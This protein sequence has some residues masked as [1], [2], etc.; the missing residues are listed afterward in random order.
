MKNYLKKI[1]TLIITLSMVIPMP[2]EV[3][4]NPENQENQT[5]ETSPKTNTMELTL[6]KVETGEKT[7][8]FVKNPKQPEIYTLRTDFK[9]E[10]D[11]YLIKDKKANKK[12]DIN[13]QPYVATVGEAANDEERRKVNRDIAL[14]VFG[15]YNKPQEE[16]KITYDG[17]VNAAK[18]GKPE[19]KILKHERSG[20]DAYGF[21]N[22]ALQHFLYSGINQKIQV[23]HLFQQLDNFEKYGKK[24]GEEKD[25]ITEQSGPTGSLVKIMPLPDDPIKG[26]QFKGFAPEDNVFTLIPENAN[27]YSVELR[28]NRAH[29]DVKYDCNDGTEVPARTLYYGQAIPKIHDSDVPTKVGGIFQGWK[30]S[31]NLYKKDGT[32]AFKKGEIIKDRNGKSINTLNID[33]VM[34]AEDVTFEAVWKDKPKA[35]YSVQFWVEKADHADD[36]SLLDKYEYMSTRVYKQIDTGTRPNLDNESVGEVEVEENGVKKTLPGL[37]FPDLNHTR[38]EKIWNGDK[39]DR[40]RSLFLNKFFVYNKKLTDQENADPKESNFIKSVSSTGQTIYNIYYDRQEYD[41]Y[42]TKSNALADEETFYPEI[43]GRDQKNN[44]LIKLGGPGKPYHYK[45]RFNE[46]MYKWPDDAKQTKGFTPGWQSYGWGVNYGKPKW[47]VHLDTPPYRL[48]ADQFLDMTNYD[49]WDGY[50]KNIDKGDGTKITAKDFTTLSFGIKQRKSSIPHHM[51]FWMDG[52]KPGETIIRYDL[53][54]TKA[55]TADQDYTHRSPSVL[56]FTP[57][58]SYVIEANQENGRVTEDDIDTI[59]DEREEISP[60]NNKSRYDIYGFKSPIG[61]LRFIPAFFSNADE[62]GDPLDGHSFKENGYLQFHY[63]RNK[64]PL[65]FNTDPSKTKADDEFNSTNQL[66]TFYEFP[67]KCLSP[68]LFKYDENVDQQDREYFKEDP[69]NS[70]DN[71]NNLFKLGLTDLLEVD[72]N[73]NYKKDDDGK[74]LIKRP[75]GISKDEVFKGWA[76]D[77]AGTK[78]VRDNPN[79]I[80][81]THPV[82][83]YAVW[84]T[85]DYKWNLS[86]DTDGGK[87]FAADDEVAIDKNPINQTGEELKLDAKNITTGSKRILEGD[88]T[89]KKEVQYPIMQEDKDGKQNFTVIQGQSLKDP[90]GQKGSK[91]QKNVIKDGYTFVGWEVVRYKKDAQGQ[92]TNEVDDSYRKTYGVPELYSFN[93]KVVSPISL[94][95]IW[96]KNDMTKVKVVHHFL[97]KNF[98]E[99]TT[100]PFNY[101][102][103]SQRVGNYTSAIGSKQ[104]KK[105]ILATDDELK[106]S[107]DQN[108]KKL[109]ESYNK[110]FVPPFNNSYFQSFKVK[111]PQDNSENTNNTEDKTKINDN[112]FHFFYRPF[113]IRE[114]KVNYLDE[115][116]KPLLKKENSAAEKKKI[117]EKYSIIDQ[118]NVIS[119]CRHYDARNYKPIQ[120]WKLTSDPQKQLFYDVEEATNKLKGTTATGEKGVDYFYNDNEINFFYKDIRVIDVPKD[121][122]TPEGYVR[123]KFKASEGG[124]FGEDDKGNPIKEINYDVVKGLKF[125]IIPVPKELKA[126]ETKDNNK[127]YITPEKDNHFVKWDKDS[128]LPDGTVLDKNEYVFT[129][130]FDWA[131]L[132]ADN[133]VVTES[134]KDGE[135][136]WINNFSPTLDDLKALIKIK[137]EGEKTEALP[138]DATIEFF[139]ESRNE[140]TTDDAIYE[141][142]KENNVAKDDAPRII[143]LKAKVTLK[144]TAKPKEV[145]FNIKVYKNCYEASK[146]GAKPEILDK[147][148]EDKLP[149]YVKVTVKVSEDS[150]KIYYVNPEAMVEIPEITLTDDQKK[151]INFINWTADVDE[152]NKDGAKDGVFEFDN[153]HKFTKDTVITPRGVEDVVEQKDPNKKPI[154][155]KNYIKVFVKTTD[156]ATDA[157][158][159]DK[160]FWV[161]PEKE[162]TIS[163]TN[164]EGKKPAGKD[165]TW[166]FDS[167]K[168]KANSKEYKTEIK[169]TFT[170]G[171]TIEAHYVVEPKTMITAAKTVKEKVIA[172]G[173]Q[174]TPEELVTNKYNSDDPNNKDNLP[175]GTTFKFVGTVDTSTAG[176]I[177]AKVEIKYPN[178][179]KVTKEVKIVVVEDVVEQ[180]DPNKK[181]IVPENYVKVEFEAGEGGRIE[182]TLAY[183]VNPDVEVDMTSYAAGIKKIPNVGYHTSGEDWTNEAAKTLKGTFTDLQTTFVFKF[184]KSPDIVEKTD[185]NTAIPDGYVT[186]TFKTDGNGKVAGSDEK[187]YYINPNAG[188]MLATENSA[189]EK[190]LTVPAVTPNDHYKFAGWNQNLDTT[191]PITEDKEYVAQFEQKKQIKIFFDPNGGNWNGNTLIQEIGCYEGDVIKIINAPERVGYKFL[192]W[193][194]SEYQ[195]GASYTAE[196]NHTFVAQWEKAPEP[197]T[198]TEN[199]NDK[200][201]GKT[202]I[203]NKTKSKGYNVSPNTGDKVTIYL[204]IS[205]LIA[206]MVAIVIQGSKR[207]KND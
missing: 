187:V 132:T 87:F 115:R 168:D 154:V 42:F 191:S 159:F 144:G 158:K 179:D 189:D 138:N 56:G 175:E 120:G 29:F 11:S 196:H 155:P 50:V 112:E 98:A 90:L 113:R 37:P 134:Y 186:L 176:E 80:M 36:A 26:S 188:I 41:L 49:N 185:E 180:K 85:P 207:R 66:D 148:K 126:G 13:Y 6:A 118:E 57:Y 59:N 167:W 65:R 170:D 30:P 172:K 116:A 75:E 160:T 197:G 114:Y 71:P 9:V 91:D 25:L 27:G 21:V 10:R 55:D 199:Q 106:S 28:Y 23:K 2:L 97:D 130:I 95:A 69:E 202:K 133:K 109:Y 108:I 52:F 74:Y 131:D 152:Q 124:S 63:K 145:E 61:E 119:Q 4:A 81:P 68:D 7:E 200:I 128:L 111:K 135:G 1:I 99:D 169:D 143:K 20:K 173:T 161:N 34:P 178:G 48:N 43:Y 88:G 93:N 147:A 127:Y 47:P 40:G 129:A 53:V 3:F 192:Y 206:A 17:I 51:D 19:G 182:G 153:R 83:L 33:V 100:K 162:V 89:N 157:T 190:I 125:G 165:Y 102:Q 104:G 72:K 203:V 103:D 67:L 181:P 77:P 201:A 195:P 86:I 78:L 137:A 141:M 73:G 194:A 44:E 35:D 62:F 84:D 105:W 171:V 151:S 82:N 164:P 110:K 139:D 96:V 79:E 76:L 22:S 184:E 60:N 156:K 8:D 136:K 177:T 101:T 54:R 174:I 58:K 150:K 24:P 140:I 193:N 122:I 142:V 123:V 46:L 117:V 94:K 92:Y 205:A 38:L 32:L 146:T 14:P 31:V 64:Y 204:Y 39:F 183:Y 18:D 5:F 198:S 166:K 70:I 163:V 107:K 45:A 12:Y 149:D 16:F 121:N 15:G